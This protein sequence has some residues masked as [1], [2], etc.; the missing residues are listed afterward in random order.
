[1]IAALATLAFLTALWM[2][3]VVGAAV[4]ERSGGK[5]LA[6]LRGESLSAAIA[7]RPVRVRHSRYRTQR[8][9]RSSP[10][11]RAAA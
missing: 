11:M 6:A 7:T 2:L 1:M 9:L 3:I 4:F 10:Q 8:P 5:I